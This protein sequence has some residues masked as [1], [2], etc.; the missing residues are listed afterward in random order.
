MKRKRPGL[1]L[2]MRLEAEKRMKIRWRTVWLKGE[3]L[4][5]L[6]NG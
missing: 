2:E 4:M 3:S 1:L 6:G 5:R